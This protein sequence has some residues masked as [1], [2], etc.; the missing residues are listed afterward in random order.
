MDAGVVEQGR[1]GD[2]ETEAASAGLGEKIKE[3]VKKEE[4]ALGAAAE[5]M[6]EAAGVTPISH[7]GEVDRRM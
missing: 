6:D 1:H 5:V 7:G 3:E 2:G 4:R